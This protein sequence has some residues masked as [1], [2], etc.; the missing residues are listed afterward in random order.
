[1]EALDVQDLC[2]APFS[3]VCLFQFAVEFVF[4][5][6]TKF[7]IQHIHTKKKKKKCY[8]FL[9]FLNFFF[10]EKTRTS[11]QSPFSFFFYLPFDSLLS[12]FFILF[13]FL[14]LFLFLSIPFFFSFV[15]SFVRL[16][17]CSFFCCL[18]VCV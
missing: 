14:F 3:S 1:M 2:D 4:Y 6:F 15:R 18:F 8:F 16:P 5:P 13:F 9:C 10:R 11:Y 12:S 7:G 17:V